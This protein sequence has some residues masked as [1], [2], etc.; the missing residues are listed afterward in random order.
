[1][2]NEVF[3]DGDELFRPVGSEL[4]QQMQYLLNGVLHRSEELQKAAIIGNIPPVGSK[5]T[6]VIVEEVSQAIR[7]SQQHTLI[8]IMSP[9]ALA[10][11]LKIGIPADG[12]INARQ[13]RFTRGIEEKLEIPVVKETMMFYL[14]P[15]ENVDLLQQP[16]VAKKDPD[17]P[18]DIV[19][20][21]AGSHGEVTINGIPVDMVMDLYSDGH[22]KP[23]VFELIQDV[24]G[25]ITSGDIIL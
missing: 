7:N 25:Q 13:V 15:Q 20:L 11:R 17:S 16:F 5:L 2:S 9:A 24:A 14:T 4:N 19:L 18:Q 10:E 6:F 23:G 12:S 8:S 3:H 21:T 22:E 1:M